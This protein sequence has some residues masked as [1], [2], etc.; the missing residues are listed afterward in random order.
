V[1]YEKYTYV[2]IYFLQCRGQSVQPGMV[3]HAC[4]PSTWILETEGLEVKGQPGLYCL[5]LK[6]QII[7]SFLDLYR[8]IIHKILLALMFFFIGAD[9]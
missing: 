3:V 1:P 6:N 8:Q 5:P 2:K 4:N 9:S 7:D